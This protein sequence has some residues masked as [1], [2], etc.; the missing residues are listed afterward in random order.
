M[1]KEQEEQTSVQL[2]NEDNL[3][4]NVLLAQSPHVIRVNE[5]RMEVQ[6][7]TT[8]GE[9]K[10]VLN[11]TGHADRYLSA[12]RELLSIKAT[13]SPSGYPVFMKRWTRTGYLTNNLE[14]NKDEW[15][16]AE[17]LEKLAKNPR[18]LAAFT[19]PQY[20]QVMKELGEN[21]QQAMQK[22]GNNP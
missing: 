6:A 8:R 3:L 13:G 15:A 11:P 4:L 19:D 7:L 22:Y 17:L 10:V 14:K 2:S 5:N 18:L 1:R 12:V 21:P 16:N 9:A 20:S